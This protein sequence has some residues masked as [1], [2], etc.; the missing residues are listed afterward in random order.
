MACVFPVERWRERQVLRLVQARAGDQ[1]K[2][3]GSRPMQ[4]TCSSGTNRVSVKYTQSHATLGLGNK[5]LGLRI[6]GSGFMM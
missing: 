4:C 3:V 6:Q 1:A 5:G 2:H